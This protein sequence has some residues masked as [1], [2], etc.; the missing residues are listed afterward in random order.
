[1]LRLQG[2]LAAACEASTGPAA[3]LFGRS[4]T[5]AN[6]LGMRPLAAHCHFDLGRLYRQHRPDDL[7]EQHLATAM[8]TYEALGMR[9]WHAQVEE[10]SRAA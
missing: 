1:M 2:A 8:A 9:R 6:E 7:A 10:V 4:L 3:E 5:L